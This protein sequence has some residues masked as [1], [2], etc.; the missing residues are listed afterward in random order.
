MK[1]HLGSSSNLKMLAEKISRRRTQ[2]CSSI[3]AVIILPQVSLLHHLSWALYCKIWRVLLHCLVIPKPGTP[4][5]SQ[6]YL[7]DSKYEKRLFAFTLLRGIWVALLTYPNPTVHPIAFPLLTQIATLRQWNSSL[8][9]WD[10]VEHLLLALWPWTI[11]PLFVYV[12]ALPHRLEREAT[13]FIVQNSNSRPW[14][15]FSF[16]FV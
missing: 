8:I 5:F 6:H 15:K 4:L 13:F 7:R 11:Q 16:L 2:S 14:M 10:R 3:K 9:S 12:P 1:G